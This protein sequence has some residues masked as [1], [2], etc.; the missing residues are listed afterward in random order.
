[1]IK[2]VEQSLIV[3]IN[4]VR[5]ALLASNRRC[6]KL[7]V[8]KGTHPPR[9]QAIIELAKEKLIPIE[10]ISKPTFQNKFK[11]QVHQGIAGYFSVVVTFELENLIETA[12]QIS[13]LPTLVILDGIQDPQNLGAIIR[14]AE[15]LGIQGMILPKHGASSLTKTV[16]KCS[17]GAIEYLPI[18]RVNNLSRCIERLKTAGFWIAGVV[19]DG[20]IPCYKYQFDT[21]VAL[22]IGGEE[23]GVR[24][25]LKKSCDITLSIPMQGKLGSLNA[26]SASTVVFYEN[27]RQKKMRNDAKE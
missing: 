24:P 15:T 8:E 13:S 20:E 18:S 22:V 26:A 1:M 3:G 2:P 4:S 17:S 9:I 21:P 11:N 23:K 6:Y 14:S 27:L 12:F 25:L 5:E 16:A 10:P 7:I 19:P